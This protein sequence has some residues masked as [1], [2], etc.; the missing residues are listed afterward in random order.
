MALINSVAGPLDTADLGFTLR[1]EHIVV[2]SP[3]RG[4]SF[5]VWNRQEEIE[6]AVESDWP[7]N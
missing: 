1:H 3:A 5:S 6:K 7:G 2:M 4:A